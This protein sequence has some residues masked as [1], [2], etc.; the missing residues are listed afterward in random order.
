[1]VG[2]PRKSLPPVTLVMLCMVQKLGAKTATARS[3]PFDEATPCPSPANTYR[4]QV[5]N[6]DGATVTPAAL[7]W[8]L[9]LVALMLLLSLIRSATLVL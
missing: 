8:S 4:I 6:P 1:M 3:L 2:K 7:L 5:I 9:K